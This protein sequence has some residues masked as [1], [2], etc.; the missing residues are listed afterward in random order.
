[1]NH[2]VPD[3]P[4]VVQGRVDTKED[5]VVLLADAIWPLEEYLPEY[6]LTIGPELAN[7]ATYDRLKEIF[8]EHHGAHAVYM[9][10]NGR[11]QKAGEQYW[12]DGSPEVY[13]EVS[14]LLG[15]GAVR[16]R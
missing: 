10:A 13:A 8:A 12:L 15:S 3:M 5:G 7:K 14:A 9:H 11:W 1:M 2:L 6:Y 4:I 16:M